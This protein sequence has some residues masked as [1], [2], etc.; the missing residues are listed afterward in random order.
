[1]MMIIIIIII[2]IKRRQWWNCGSVGHK[3]YLT[4]RYNFVLLLCNFPGQ[5]RYLLRSNQIHLRLSPWWWLNMNRQM[6]DTWW[7]KCRENAKCFTFCHRTKVTF[8]RHADAY[9][10]LFRLDTNLRNSDEFYVG[11]LYSQPLTMNHFQFLAIVEL[12]A[13]QLFC[14]SPDKAAACCRSYKCC[15]LSK[16]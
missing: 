9:W 13:C 1:M 16:E 4:S 10:R 12:A 15:L 11:L 2:I 7:Y 6:S 14:C 8:Q 5:W 3:M